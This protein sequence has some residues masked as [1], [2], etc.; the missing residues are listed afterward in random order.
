MANGMAFKQKRSAEAGVSLYAYGIEEGFPIVYADGLAYFG[1]SGPSDASVSTN[2]TFTVDN[3]DT[4][5]PW[6]IAANSSSAAFDE[7]LSIY[8]IPTSG[9][10]TQVGFSTEPSLPTGAVDTGFAFFGKSV[11][12]A[13]SDSDYQLSFW[14]NATTTDGVYALYWNGGDSSIP[15]G[16][17]AVTV[18]STAP[19]FSTE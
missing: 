15:E 7:T 2:I 18:K 10:F 11:A 3:S 17:F 6:T 19:T 4:T 1:H 12:Y 14:G 8:I 9:S 16:A 5:V 13:A